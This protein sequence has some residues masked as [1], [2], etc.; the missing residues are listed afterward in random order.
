MSCIKRCD[1]LTVASHFLLVFNSSSNIAIYCWKDEKFRKVRDDFVLALI[2]TSCPDTQVLLGLLGW[3]SQPAEGGGVLRGGGAPNLRRDT[4][5]IT[6]CAPW[7][8]GASSAVP[9]ATSSRGESNG[10]VETGFISQSSRI[11]SMQGS[12]PRKSI[13]SQSSCQTISTIFP[14]Q[15]NLTSKLLEM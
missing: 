10:I 14:D 3:G 1:F 8:P 2:S 4:T 6:T 5:T 9:V 12:R 11:S 15:S 7:D 13:I